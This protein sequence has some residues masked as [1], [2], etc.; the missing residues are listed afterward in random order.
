MRALFQFRFNTEVTKEQL[1]A[2]NAILTEPVE[3]DEPGDNG[4]LKLRSW[5]TYEGS[6]NQVLEI[7]GSQ[8]R[9]ELQGLSDPNP[10]VELTERIE[11]ALAEVRRRG[12]FNSKVGVHVPDNNL[13]EVRSTMALDDA[14][15]DQLDEYLSEGWIIVAVCPQ[16]DQ[17]RPD[18]VLG[19]RDPDV[20]PR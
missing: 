15:S 19:H 14:C 8:N 6:I 20:R 13:I 10:L 12:N 17:R 2:L 7:I 16:P 5:K 9:I 11:D 4:K 18:Y 3:V 1:E